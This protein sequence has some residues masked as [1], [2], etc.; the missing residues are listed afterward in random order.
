MPAAQR[1]GRICAF[2]IPFIIALA[3]Q[4]GWPEYYKAWNGKRQV[5]APISYLCQNSLSVNAKNGHTRMQ[6]IKANS[7]QLA[8]IVQLVNQAYRGAGWTSEA[9]LIS[10]PRVDLETLQDISD[11]G[12]TIIFAATNNREALLGCVSLSPA[13]MGEW[14]LSMLAVNP[15][16]QANGMGKAIL[17]AAEHYAREQG[18]TSVKISV[19]QQRESLIAWYERRGYR[20]TGALEPFPYDDPSVGTPL[21]G[22][23]ALV[24]LTKPL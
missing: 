15:A 24:S 18:A 2:S 23:L 22:D 17:A 7:N 16:I 8:E 9:E 20:R 11:N 12:N 4:M 13:D 5:S 21:R 14:Y 10:G 19:I 1:S 6:L 3:I